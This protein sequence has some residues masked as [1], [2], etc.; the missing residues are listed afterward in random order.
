MRVFYLR[1]RAW[2]YSIA[3]GL[4]AVI[5]LATEM[6]ASTTLAQ[7]L[8]GDPNIQQQFE[9]ISPPTNKH[10]YL[11]AP[12]QPKATKVPAKKAEKKNKAPTGK[13]N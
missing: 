4:V 11:L 7:G 2:R 1:E 10:D 3:W 6:T 9:S 8:G 13:T 5:L 12:A